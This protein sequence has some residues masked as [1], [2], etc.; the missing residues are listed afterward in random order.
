MLGAHEKSSC[1]AM[2]AVMPLA[3]VA[4]LL[5]SAPASA[6]CG[7]GICEEGEECEFD[8]DPGAP[9][10]C[11]LPNCGCTPERPLVDCELYD[12]TGNYSCRIDSCR[13]GC[14]DGNLDPGEACDDGPDNSNTLPDHCRKSCRLPW[15]GDGVVDTGEE[16]DDGGRNSDTVPD[17]CRWDCTPPRC[18]DGV[19]DPGLGEACDEGPNNSADPNATCNLA[20]LIPGCGNGMLE[21]WEACDDGNTDPEDDCTELCR[22]NVCGDLRLRR[23]TELCEYL[24]ALEPGDCRYDCGQDVALCGNGSVDQGE[25]CD[26]GSDRNSDSPDA[27]CRTNCLRQRCGDGITDTG[28]D[29]DGQ[30]GCAPDCRWIGRR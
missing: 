16:C 2:Y 28:E 27:R 12:D 3:L 17:S 20:C 19:T 26:D 29:C 8:P 6:R 22:R 30:P 5:P 25:E 13:E 14:G 18:G 4:V 21:T 1:R 11:C 23:G 7:D 24:T 10:I 15:C 9:D